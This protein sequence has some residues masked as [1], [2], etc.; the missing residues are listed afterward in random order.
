[1]KFD[2]VSKEVYERYHQNF[3]EQWTWLSQYP[4]CEKSDYFQHKNLYVYNN[5]YACELAN[6]HFIQTPSSFKVWLGKFQSIQVKCGLCDMC[7]FC[8]QMNK[9]GIN[10]CGFC[11]QQF[12]LSN[13]DLLKR[14]KMADLVAHTS[15]HE[16]ID[17]Y[18]TKQRFL[19]YLTDLR[20]LL[21]L[22]GENY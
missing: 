11:Y 19:A 4:E 18:N 17:Y 14:A 6:I 9:F 8:P 16:Y 12:T 10:G 13:N 1:M 15:W 20:Q 7:I 2:I 5:N 21:K 22:Y 3:I